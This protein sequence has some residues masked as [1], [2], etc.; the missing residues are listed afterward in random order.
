MSLE[1]LT[2]VSALKQ[3]GKGRPLNRSLPFKGEAILVGS[4]NGHRSKSYKTSS[5]PF[6]EK[7]R[8]S[9]ID[10]NQQSWQHLKHTPKVTKDITAYERLQ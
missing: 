5:W 8:E 3:R 10:R 4:D 9:K 1:W 6:T 7:A 2:S